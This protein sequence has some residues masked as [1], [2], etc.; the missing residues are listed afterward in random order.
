M[1]NCRKSSREALRPAMLS[2][3]SCAAAN[4]VALFLTC[5]V[6]RPAPPLARAMAASPTYRRLN[7]ATRDGPAKYWGDVNDKEEPH[8]EVL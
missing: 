7:L 6:S 3:T 4:P 8:G 5:L 1:R 2:R